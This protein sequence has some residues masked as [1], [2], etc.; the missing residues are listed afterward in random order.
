MTNLKCLIDFFLCDHGRDYI[1]YIGMGL[2]N[3]MW[4]VGKCELAIMHALRKTCG[5]CFLGLRHFSMQGG[6]I[7][8]FKQA[9]LWNC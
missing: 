8:T 4:F 6:S 9:V 5:R 7:I 3:H 2:Y 1:A